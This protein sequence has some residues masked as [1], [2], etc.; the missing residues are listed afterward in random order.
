MSASGRARHDH[1]TG[2]SHAEVF[3]AERLHPC[4][5]ALV[6]WADTQCLARPALQTPH[7]M[8]SPSWSVTFC[9][10]S[11]PRPTKTCD[12][13]RTQAAYTCARPGEV[14]A[15]WRPGPPPSWT[16]RAGSHTGE[17]AAAPRAR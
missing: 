11:G 14:W 4:L 3:G 1:R 15:L 9:F 16:D 2:C 8:T 6:G 13:M 12:P 17:H 5:P 7:S 10:I